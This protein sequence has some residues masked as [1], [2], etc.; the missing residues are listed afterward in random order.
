MDLGA[1]SQL[2][3]RIDKLSSNVFT[4]HQLLLECLACR[5]YQQDLLLEALGT[6]NTGM[7][8][9][10]ASSS[11]NPGAPEFVSRKTEKNVCGGK[12]EPL[13]SDNLVDPVM[14][15]RSDDGKEVLKNA[16]TL[17]STPAP[18]VSKETCTSM[19][20][21]AATREAEQ[22][23]DVVDDNTP[24]PLL[25]RGR[26]HIRACEH[27]FFTDARFGR[28]HRCVRECAVIGGQWGPTVCS[29]ESK[30]EMEPEIV[31]AKENSPKHLDIDRGIAKDSRAGA[32]R[33][34]KK[35]A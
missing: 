15:D 30:P 27:C 34:W 32:R 35:A 26:G 23:T 21:P 4:V 20:T 2:G 16:E 22:K 19:D 29:P 6:G 14:V 31:T 1:I 24:K 12:W 5:P 10:R 9:R 28:H 18:Q 7:N 13:G 3:D 8:T 17:P 33:I 25:C 11:L